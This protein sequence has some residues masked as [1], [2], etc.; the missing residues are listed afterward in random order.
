HAQALHSHEQIMAEF[1]KNQSYTLEQIKTAFF[2]AEQSLRLNII[3]LEKEKKQLGQE[4]SEQ[5]NA[6]RIEKYNKEL[7]IKEL[8]S[9]TY[10]LGDALQSSLQKI[11]DYEAK[12][13]AIM[14]DALG[15]RRDAEIL[16]TK[17]EL[18]QT[19]LLFTNS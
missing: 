15:W 17:L 6:I 18:A 7:F 12:F 4:Y 13:K 14:E 8:E 11:V 3:E 10:Q 5:L 1:Y 2:N 9:K 19:E 16:R